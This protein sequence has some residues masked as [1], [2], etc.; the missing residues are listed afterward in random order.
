MAG[1]HGATHL[2]AKAVSKGF[3]QEGRFPGF[4]EEIPQAAVEYVAE[5]VRVPAADVAKYSLPRCFS[6]C[7]PNRPGRRSSRTGT[8]AG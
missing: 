6:R 7:S 2:K 8:G 3:G 5:L 1:R 4:V